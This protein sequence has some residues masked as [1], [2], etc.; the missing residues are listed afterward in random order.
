MERRSGRCRFVKDDSVVAQ[1]AM[2]T[3]SA[4][5]ALTTIASLARHWSGRGRC[6]SP[7][8]LEIATI[9]EPVTSRL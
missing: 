8:I 7:K 2:A 3:P 1:A 9:L 6:E 4:L 5:L